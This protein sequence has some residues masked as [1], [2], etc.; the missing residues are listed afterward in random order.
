MNIK[1]IIFY[2]VKNTYN[3]LSEE[4]IK[5]SGFISFPGSTTLKNNAIFVYY[6]GNQ[7]K[8]LAYFMNQCYTYIVV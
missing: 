5:K 6:K 2:K 3:E 1:H 7:L 4:E 8:I